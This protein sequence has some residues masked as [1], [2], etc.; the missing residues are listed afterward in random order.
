ML[1]QW[2]PSLL[3]CSTIKERM[4]YRA[5]CATTICV[6]SK[7]VTTFPNQWMM[8]RME[9]WTT[10]R[11]TMTTR[12]AVT[13]HRVWVASIYS[14]AWIPWNVS[15]QR[16]VKWLRT[17]HIQSCLFC[18]RV[19][20][21]YLFIQGQ[22]TRVWTNWNCV[23]VGTNQWLTGSTIKQKSIFAQPLPEC[24]TN[25]NCVATAIK[26]ILYFGYYSNSSSPK[27]KQSKANGLCIYVARRGCSVT[28]LRWL[29]CTEHGNPLRNH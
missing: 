5:F 1:I 11:R 28:R 2:E 9:R 19:E 14:S 23:F 29:S 8:I 10:I 4:K 7:V 17:I 3:L 22:S 13:R 16:H 21:K 15:N 6:I 18:R 27:S 24:G 25:G 26:L 20:S 12:I